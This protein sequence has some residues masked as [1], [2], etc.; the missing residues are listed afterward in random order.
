MRWRAGKI[1]QGGAALF[2]RLNTFDEDPIKVFAEQNR[3]FRFN[4]HIG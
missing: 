3:T 1:C 4:K 2:H